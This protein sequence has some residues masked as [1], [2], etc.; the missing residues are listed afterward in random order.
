MTDTPTNTETFGVTITPTFLG[1]R[2]KDDGGGRKFQQFAW[3]V[4]LERDGREMRTEWYAGTAWM[5]PPKRGAHGLNPRWTPYD[6]Y[7][8]GAD[9]LHLRSD[10]IPTPRPPTIRDIL[11]SLQIDC[12]CELWD[13]YDDLCHG[14]P[15]SEVRRMQATIQATVA[16]LRHLLGRDFE[17]FI[18]HNFDEED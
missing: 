12:R 6:I 13:E 3:T 11:E 15:Y 9:K 7:R 16:D 1:E 5:D 4:L 18:D 8:A 2:T 14:M 10:Q 17:R